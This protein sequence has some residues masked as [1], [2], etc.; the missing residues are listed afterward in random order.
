[1]APSADLVS[2]GVK[3]RAGFHLHGPLPC[4]ADSARSGATI[5]SRS[6]P[7][8]WP[9]CPASRQT[10][11][12]SGRPARPIQRGTATLTRRWGPPRSTARSTATATSTSRARSTG[13]AA[14][15]RTP[16][17][18]PVLQASHGGHRPRRPVGTCPSGHRRARR[19]DDRRLPG[20][21]KS[22]GDSGP[23]SPDCFPGRRC[24]RWLWPLTT[25]KEGRCC[26]ATFFT[27][28]SR[29][30]CAAG[31]G[32]YRRWRCSCSGPMRLGSSS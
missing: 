19:P 4:G 21:A 27:F 32:G 23:E 25:P 30:E 2:G 1:M 7:S 29:R 5:S 26:G 31:R 18:P 28:L 10:G 16:E 3:L 17:W 20:L 8:D 14:G 24:A 6:A 11:S 15:T 13:S 12:R 22:T 9:G